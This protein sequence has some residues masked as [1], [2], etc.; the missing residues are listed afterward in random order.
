MNK[1]TKKMIRKKLVLSQTSTLPQGTGDWLENK[2]KENADFVTE[3]FEKTEEVCGKKTSIVKMVESL[4]E[5]L[6]SHDDQVALLVSQD[7]KD[8]G[9]IQRKLVQL[10]NFSLKKSLLFYVMHPHTRLPSIKVIKNLLLKAITL[11]SI[12]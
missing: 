8:T 4:K 12:L 10:V 6:D 5:L 3:L 2:I 11:R 9:D 7:I 1:H